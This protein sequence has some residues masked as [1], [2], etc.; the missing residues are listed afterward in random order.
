M[1]VH[2]IGTG[3]YAN[4]YSDG[5][6]AYKVPK[7]DWK[8]DEFHVWLR[9]GLL[10]RLGF[11]VPLLGLLVDA[12]NSFRGF[13]MK[14]CTAFNGSTEHTRQ[15]ETQLR[16][17][18]AA[19]W[20][21]GD[22]KPSNLLSSDEGAYL[23]DFGLAQ[24]HLEAL[25]Q[26]ELQGA[27]VLHQLCTLQFRAPYFETGLDLD[28]WAFGITMFL[29]WAH[30]SFKESFYKLHAKADIDTWYRNTFDPCRQHSIDKVS[31]YVDQSLAHY[32]LQ[33]LEWEPKRRT[34][35]FIRDECPDVPCSTSLEP[36][37]S[38]RTIEL[39]DIKALT[40][41]DIMDVS[42]ASQKDRQNDMPETI[43]RQIHENLCRLVFVKA[44][45]MFPV[46]QVRLFHIL[47]QQGLPANHAA[48]IASL[49]VMF[50][51][52]HM[53]ETVPIAHC[54][55]LAGLSLHEFEQLMC[56]CLV[57]ALRWPSWSTSCFH[58]LNV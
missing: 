30:P 8:L 56:E 39:A 44:S 31:K 46:A 3:A 26:K 5:T 32:V 23:C 28:M 50:L 21:H 37:R 16:H 41:A 49:F 11:G 2:G 51:L 12:S 18:H 58:T 52:R 24:M 45:D 7:D 20:V 34:W 48:V 53:K 42:K 29:S 13:Q 22:I 43:A 40:L 54:A 35:A 57:Y 19:G 4:V 14:L 17:L 47:G 9:E 55:R 36:S 38:K 6:Y 10:L 27:N 33:F 15:L 25:P 1:L